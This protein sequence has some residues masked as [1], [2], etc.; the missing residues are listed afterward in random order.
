MRGVRTDGERIVRL[1]RASGRT[2]EQLA[3]ECDLAANT[4]R[5]AERGGPVD[6]AVV[7]AI[8]AVC[9]VD[10]KE[11]LASTDDGVPAAATR[12]IP[13]LL[14][15]VAGRWTGKIEQPTGPDGQHFSAMIRMEIERTGSRLHGQS[16]FAFGDLTHTC[17]VEVRWL[18]ERYFRL[19]GVSADPQGCMFNTCYFQV[20]PA[21]DRIAGRYIGFG[22]HSNCIIVGEVS[23]SRDAEKRR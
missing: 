18:F 17:N 22:P 4:I 19:D 2:Q 13:D 1:R 23:G 15:K 6:I 3:S 16:F 11:L 8:A 20:N 9:D 21:G 7:N 10:V 14:N 12:E 5:S